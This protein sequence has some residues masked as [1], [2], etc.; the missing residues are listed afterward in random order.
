MIGIALAFVVFCQTIVL[1]QSESDTIS[2]VSKTKAFNMRFYFGVNMAKCSLKPVE[3]YDI[4]RPSHENYHYY[5]NQIHYYESYQINKI[6]S[7]YSPGISLGLLGDIRLSDQFSLQ[8]NPLVNLG[9]LKIVYEC[10]LLDEEGLPVVAQYEFEEPV[11]KDETWFEMP[12]LIKYNINGFNKAYL[13]GGLAPKISVHSIR[14]IK[15]PFKWQFDNPFDLSLE[16][17]GGYKIFKD[18]CVQF[19]MSIGLLNKRSW[20]KRNNSGGWMGGY[21]WMED[22]GHIQSLRIN[23]FQIGIVF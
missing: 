22:Y 5:Q 16:F 23:Q 1:A 9:G 10:T 6:E 12:L 2:A 7:F 21:E 17:G 8:F 18:F 3:G 4:I 13:I 19:K 20:L 11:L 14:I 15:L